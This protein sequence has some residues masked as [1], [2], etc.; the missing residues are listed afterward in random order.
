MRDGSDT[1]LYFQVP[2]VAVNDIGNDPGRAVTSIREFSLRIA[3]VTGRRL[4]WPPAPT[5]RNPRPM[6]IT[7]CA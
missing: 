2:L 6:C 5:T 1:V 4:A 7:K 3:I